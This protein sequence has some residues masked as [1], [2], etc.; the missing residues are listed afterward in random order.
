MIPFEGI[1]LGAQLLLIL[2]FF[3]IVAMCFWTTALFVRAQR[4]IAGAPAARARA[5]G[6]LP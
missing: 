5:D 3:V 6:R 4:A 1:P 2:A